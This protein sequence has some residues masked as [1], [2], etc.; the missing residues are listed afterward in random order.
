MKNVKVK[1]FPYKTGEALRAS[2]GPVSRTFRHSAHK[3]SKVVSLTYRPPLTSKEISWYLFL[4]ET[5]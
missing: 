3:G 4:L 1:A 2:G 5:E